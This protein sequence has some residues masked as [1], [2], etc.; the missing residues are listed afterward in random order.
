MDDSF[1]T[2]ILSYQSLNLIQPSNLQNQFIKLGIPLFFFFTLSLS[3]QLSYTVMS[4][5]IENT[6]LK[7]LLFLFK[8]NKQHNEWNILYI[9]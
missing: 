2:S 9:E 7:T 8:I 6:I 3:Y 1:N 4:Y 5:A